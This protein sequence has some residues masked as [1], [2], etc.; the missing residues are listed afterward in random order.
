MARMI[1]CGHCG[2]KYPWQPAM[3]HRPVRCKCGHR[4]EITPEPAMP[5]AKPTQDQ[6]Y[7]L[8]EEVHARQTETSPQ[9]AEKIGPQVQCP[10]CHSPLEPGVMICLNCGMNIK[11]GR[12]PATRPIPPP[13]ARPKPV[14][15]ELAMATAMIGQ[16]K[17][18][19][20]QRADI[21]PDARKVMLLVIGCTL[22]IIGVCVGL[23][24]MYRD[25]SPPV[26]YLGDDKEIIDELDSGSTTIDQ[27]LTKGNNLVMVGGMNSSQAL[28]LDQKLRQMGAKDVRI[29][30]AINGMMVR[31]LIIQL[32]ADAAGRKALFDF[33]QEYYSASMNKPDVDVGQKYIR[34]QLKL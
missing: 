15:N 19:N 3:A 17:P 16:P 18:R 30:S 7:A 26:V 28:A 13:M 21:N 20:I 4:I 32:P 6:T 14:V 33:Q 23:F 24:M 29:T 11:T 25:S 22:L 10:T 1:Q 2:Q 9:D 12:R 8:A 34:L 5:E 31:E 27:F